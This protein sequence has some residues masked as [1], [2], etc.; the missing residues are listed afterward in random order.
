MECYRHTRG[1]LT[2]AYCLLIV[3]MAEFRPLLIGGLFKLIASIVL[4]YLLAF[5]LV[6]RTN[7]LRI[8]AAGLKLSR[9][10]GFLLVVNLQWA[11]RSHTRFP[12]PDPPSLSPLFQ[13]PPPTFSL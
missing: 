5:V 10:S 1:F 8:L 3:G 9:S 4:A 7:I 11:E 2:A 6:H 12:V 13:R